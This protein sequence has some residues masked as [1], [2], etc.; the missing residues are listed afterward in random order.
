MLTGWGSQLEQSEMGT[1]ERQTIVVPC[2]DG[3]ALSLNRKKLQIQLPFAES[4]VGVDQTLNSLCPKY[5]LQNVHAAIIHPWYMAYLCSSHCWRQHLDAELILPELQL[6]LPSILTA[7]FVSVHGRR[8][9]VESTCACPT[10]Q[11]L[12]RRCPQHLPAPC[13]RP[14]QCQAGLSLEMQGCARLDLVLLAIANA[15]AAPSTR[16]QPAVGMKWSCQLMS[17]P[18]A[19]TSAMAACWEACGA[20]QWAGQAAN[21]PVSTDYKG[22]SPTSEQPFWRRP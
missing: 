3:T 1:L 20:I 9:G 14:Q 8:A 15:E 18:E 22:W 4:C 2:S 7:H 16:W 19:Q 13:R 11:C 5:R 17:R 6:Q 12:R 10:G 21:A